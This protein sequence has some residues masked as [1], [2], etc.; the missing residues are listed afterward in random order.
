MC[1]ELSAFF[2]AVA[3][4]AKSEDG[5]MMKIINDRVLHAANCYVYQPEW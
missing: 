1:S 3:S 5:M 4:H 2:Y